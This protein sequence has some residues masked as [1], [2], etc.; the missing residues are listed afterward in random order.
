MRQS[1]HVLYITL[2]DFLLQ[3]VFLGL[4]I[5]V[6]YAVAAKG[7]QDELNKVEEIKKLMGTSDLT[8]LTDDL[9]RLAPL[10]ATSREIAS[11]ISSVGGIE[12]ARK[13]LDDHANNQLGQ[14]HVSCLQNSEIVT[15]L[16]AFEDH[17]DV[18]SPYTPKFKELLSEIKVNSP[19]SAMPLDAFKA[20]FAP[21]LIHYPG[22][23]F[24]VKLVEH[25]HDSRPRDAVNH[26]FWPKIIERFR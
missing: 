18:R 20:T 3:L 5:G 13:I 12:K 16:D 10:Q 17:I 24:N 14:G 4:I 8:R 9:T 19:I 1:E 2:V 11:A 21:L 7:D 6:I 25:S 22:C 15:T 23:R 26:I